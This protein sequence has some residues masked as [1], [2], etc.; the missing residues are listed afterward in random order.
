MSLFLRHSELPYEF[1]LSSPSFF[2][3]CD[4]C[5]AGQASNGQQCVSCGFGTYAPQPLSGSCL[6]CPPGSHTNEYVASTECNACDAGSFSSFPG[7]DCTLCSPGK[8]S[9]SGQTF[10]QQCLPGYYA[11]SQGSG[12][13]EPCPSLAL[14]S[15]R[16]SSSCS[17]ASPGYYLDPEGSLLCPAFGVCLGGAELPRPR[18]GFWVDRGSRASPGTMFRCSR[19]TCTGTQSNPANTSCWTINYRDLVEMGGITCNSDTLQCLRGSGGPLCGKSVFLTTK[20]VRTSLILSAP[21][22]VLNNTAPHHVCLGSCQLGF[23]YSSVQRLCI[24]CTESSKFTVAIVV[25]LGVL[26]AVVGALHAGFTALPDWLASSS[27]AGAVRQMDSGT[28]RIIISTYQIVQSVS[29]SIDI[30]LPEPFASL[31]K[32]MSLVSL[33]FISPDCF[34]NERSKFRTVFLW[35][36]IPFIL[37]NLNFVAYLLRSIVGSKCEC[38]TKEKQQ[39]RYRQHMHVFLMGSYLVLPSVVRV[40]FQALDCVQL[41]KGSVFLSSNTAVSCLSRSFRAFKALD[42][43]FVCVSLSIPLGWFVAVWKRHRAHQMPSGYDATD[44]AFLYQPY[45][46]SFYFFEVFEVYRRILFISILPLLS[47]KTSRRAALGVFFS[48]LSSVCYREGEPFRKEGINNILAF[49]AQY[50]ILVRHVLVRMLH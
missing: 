9:S 28:F 30:V 47:T 22:P 31:I 49:V 5:K 14:T 13:C 12:S 26:G 33:D 24:S 27:I 41:A 45:R 34:F 37:A 7:N 40:Q 25:V 48:I 36:F 2:A 32:L 4:Y 1:I 23:T 29:W 15:T 44:L 8:Y 17:L 18:P 35:T 20:V 39:Q 38:T 43:I 10:C 46:R 6:G 19:E 16:G 3:Q 11:S 50:T 42:I 21:L